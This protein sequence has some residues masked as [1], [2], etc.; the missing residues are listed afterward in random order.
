MCGIILCRPRARSGALLSGALRSPRGESQPLE[1]RPDLFIVGAPKTGTTS[2]YEYLRGHPQV[3][4]CPVKEPRYFAPDLAIESAGH[5]LVYGRDEARYLALFE[6]ATTQKRLG[7][8]S[9]RYIYSDQA[10]A[11]IREFAPRPFVVVGLRDPVEL[12]YALHNQSVSEG[13]EPLT[14]FEAALAAE[15]ARLRGENLP[16]DMPA[17][18]L[19]Y[20]ER[21][22]L[23]PRLKAWRETFGADRV[24]VFVFED[25]VRDPQTV[26]RA[27]LEF[28]EVDPD[29]RPP[30]FEAFNASQQPR[31]RLLRRL[32]D[33]R[34]A[35]FLA[36]KVLPRL[37]GDAGA[38]RLARAVTK[39]N[40]RAS[41]RPEMS[42]ALRNRLRE[43]FAAD[44]ADLSE[45]LGRNLAQE[46][47]AA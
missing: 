27:L 2:L 23:A 41:P 9:V 46:W 43:T 3:F 40:R 18:H 34:P 25:L 31:S 14:D 10:P 30:A 5:D 15:P 29:Y 44:V 28:L 6:D 19:V 17:L 33:T 38:H 7:E 37:I 11:L 35:Q 36:W 39:A 22:K 32:T 42:S 20:V 24:H 12:I 8:A 16:A 45:M 1:R 21:G 47:W 4:M 13:I 26:F